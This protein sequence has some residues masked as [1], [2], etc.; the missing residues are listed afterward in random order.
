MNTVIQET[1]P[2]SVHRQVMD[3][4]SVKDY[5]YLKAYRQDLEE[6]D[7]EYLRH[8]WDPEG[9]YLWLIKANG[10]ELS[11]LGVHPKLHEYALAA[12]SSAKRETAQGCDVLLVTRGQVK[13]IS[14]DLAKVEALKMDYLIEGRTI[15][16]AD[17]KPLATFLVDHFSR[18]NHQT[19]IV[20]FGTAPGLRLTRPQKIAL[21][22]IAQC[23]LVKAWQSFFCSLEDIQLNGR[24]LFEEEEG[25]HVD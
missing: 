1:T 12:L 23:E 6:S 4:V 22:H 18:G 11:R 9:R 7:L 2:E 25:A 16:T 5:P 19:G 10:T 21:R 14:A 15:K 8:N 24:S 17:G 3:L 13:R 20:K